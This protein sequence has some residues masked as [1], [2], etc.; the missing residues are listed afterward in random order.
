MDQSNGNELDE[1]QN[2][3]QESQN[4]EQESQSNGFDQSNKPQKVKKCILILSMHRSGSS[5]LV[6]SILKYFDKIPISIGLHPLNVVSDSSQPKG[7][8]ENNYILSYNYNFM[9]HRFNLDWYNINPLL[10]TI[11][12]DDL[13]KLSLLTTKLFSEKLHGP[14]LLKFEQ[15]IDL[16]ND[17]KLIFEDFVTYIELKSQIKDSLTN[18]LLT[19]YSND[20]ENLTNDD[21]NLTND[22]EN[23]TNDDENSTNDDENSTN[24][25][26]NSTN[27]DDKNSTDE[28]C[29]MKDPRIVLLWPMYESVLQ[30]LG[31]DCNIIVIDR[32]NTEIAKSLISRNPE[33]FTDENT[34]LTL[35]EYYKTFIQYIISTTT[36]TNKILNITFNDLINDPNKT[37]TQ[38]GQF[39]NF[40]T[41]VGNTTT[42]NEFID[43][44]LKHF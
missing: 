23:S 16:N 1:S 40:N 10:H 34:A 21:E 14:V 36:L 17:E 41:S 44:K 8:F 25:D 33:I 18:I 37:M 24:D 38:I 22:D 29:I 3:K 30:N 13:N 31:W 42:L 4:N 2:N 5:A 43:K 6:G 7:Y 35:C 32:D 20:D 27:D 11:L 28:W 12:N 26:K 9:K 19:E 15:H 39:L